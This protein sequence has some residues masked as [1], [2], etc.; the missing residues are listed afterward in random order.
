MKYA[1]FIIACILLIIG[2][3][4]CG[5]RDKSKN[6]ASYAFNKDTSVV[7]APVARKPEPWVKEGIAC[8]GIVIV[9]DNAGKPLRMKEVHVKVKSIEPEGIKLEALEDINL[10]RT[11]ECNK[12][13]FKK[14]ESWNE[15]H[16]DLFKTQK[17]AIQFIN[18]KY[19]GLRVKH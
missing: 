10:G 19:P 9:V 18:S 3:E 14:G 7:T 5:N 16:G 2:T 11:I 8:W 4:S 6:I 1:L 15:Q 17:E 13:N 12:V